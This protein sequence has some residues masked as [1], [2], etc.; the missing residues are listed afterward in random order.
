MAQR[1]CRTVPSDPCDCECLDTQQTN[2]ELLTIQIQ[3]TNGVFGLKERCI[4]PKRLEELHKF[5]KAHDAVRDHEFLETPEATF[6]SS[7]PA[8][9]AP[10]PETTK[11]SQ[12]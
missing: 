4:L 2:G 7:M 11:H 8:P 1:R 5:N 10:G 9:T 12:L 6:P 3:N